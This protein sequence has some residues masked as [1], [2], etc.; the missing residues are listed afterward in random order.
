M[1]L[2]QPFEFDPQS[3]HIYRR[4]PHPIAAAL[5]AGEFEA[6]KLLLSA[7]S[8]PVSA[9]SL[10]SK[11]IF[12][13]DSTFSSLELLLTSPRFEPGVCGNTIIRRFAAEGRLEAVRLLLKDNRVDPSAENSEALYLAFNSTHFEIAKVRPPSLCLISSLCSQLFSADLP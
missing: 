11:V 10:L 13:E 5:D 3:P 7:P 6:M 12:Y 2:I 1:S 8:C 4:Q 9:E